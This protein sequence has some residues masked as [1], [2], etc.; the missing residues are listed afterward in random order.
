MAGPCGTQARSGLVRPKC[1][2]PRPPRM[3]PTA[4]ESTP[5]ARLIHER[6]GGPGPSAPFVAGLAIL[7]LATAGLLV[8][9]ALQDPNPTSAEAAF[10]D[11]S[12]PLAKLMEA[13]GLAG[14]RNAS[15]LMAAVAVV[16]AGLLGRRLFHHDGVGLLAAIF[17][18]LDPAFLALGHLALPT[19]PILALALLGSALITTANNGTRWLGSILLAAAAFSQPLVAAW[20]I[21]LAA[22]VLLRG[23]I[24]AAPKHLWSALAQVALLPLLAGAAG[25]ALGAARDPSC[26]AATRFDVLRLANAV[27]A[28]PTMIVHNPALWFGGLAV[29]VALGGAAGLHVGSQ[30]KLARLPGRIQMRLPEPLPA[31]HARSLWLLLLILAA[32]VPM[33]WAPLFAIALAAGIRNLARDAPGFGLIVALGAVAFGALYLVRIWPLVTGTAT[34]A[35]LAALLPVV[36]WAG[37]SAC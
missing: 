15:A 11:D 21:P 13:L 29:A 24:Y 34:P 18:V 19:T 26:F 12:S 8:A 32:P 30:F 33:L 4:N 14:A 6:T 10:A 28:G 36:P 16:G 23:N 20:A 31:R 2:G 5:S 27:D 25:Q 9:L 3:P 1:T 37:Q 17:V 7:A 22:L 35:E